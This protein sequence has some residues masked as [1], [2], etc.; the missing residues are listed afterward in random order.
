MPRLGG[1]APLSQQ[2]LHPIW[3]GGLQS[4]RTHRNPGLREVQGPAQVTRPGRGGAGAPSCRFSTGCPPYLGRAGGQPEGPRFPWLRV[5]CIIE[6]YRGDSHTIQRTHL[7]CTT[8][9]FLA[10]SQ[11]HVTIA[12]KSRMFSSPQKETPHLQAVPIPLLGPWQLPVC[13]LCGFSYPGP[14]AYVA[15]HGTRPFVS[16]CFRRARGFRGSSTS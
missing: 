15:S 11:S 3:P 7:K 1:K 12:I 13:F 4:R 14:F 6:L 5:G 10:Y 2:L 16:G 8:H 9:W